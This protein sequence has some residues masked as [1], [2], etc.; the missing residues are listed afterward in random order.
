LQKKK[1]SL[2]EIEYTIKDNK[3]VELNSDYIITRIA[4]TKNEDDKLNYLLGVFEVAN[5]P[6]FSDAIPIALIKDQ[7]VF[8][9]INYIDVNVTKYYK[10]LRYT[11]PILSLIPRNRDISPIKLYG[12]PASVINTNLKKD[13][14]PTNLPLIIIYTQNSTEPLGKEEKIDCEVSLQMKKK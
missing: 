1:N 7:E 12:K 10:Y 5:D 13:F 9:E 14:Q 2:Q 6:S 8:D 4:W 3:T 11:P